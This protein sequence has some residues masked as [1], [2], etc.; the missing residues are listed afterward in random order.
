MK[1]VKS[2]NGA[3][4]ARKKSTSVA[5]KKKKRAASDTESDTAPDE[6]FEDDSDGWVPVSQKKSKSG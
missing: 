4:S 2:S 5:T 3:K 1:P 6:S